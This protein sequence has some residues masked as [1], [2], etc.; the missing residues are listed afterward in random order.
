MSPNQERFSQAYKLIN[1]SEKVQVDK[2]FT[3]CYSVTARWC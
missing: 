3:N 2:V 1:S